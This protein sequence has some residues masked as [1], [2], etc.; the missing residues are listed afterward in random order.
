MNVI[1]KIS[2]ITAQDVADYIRISDATQD[3]LNTLNTLLT[4]AKEYVS[5]YTGRTLEDLDTLS[6]VVIVVFI[7]VQDMYD[8]RTFYV[9]TSNVNKVVES[10]LG[11]HSVNLL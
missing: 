7:L 8:N 9:D 11:L 3:D 1:S 2:Q 10:I 6:D 5:Q 4:V